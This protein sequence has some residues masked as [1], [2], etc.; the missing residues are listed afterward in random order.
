MANLKVFESTFV[1]KLRE[2]KSLDFY[3]DPNSEFDLSSYPGVVLESQDIKLPDEPPILSPGIKHDAENAEKV[4]NYLKISPLRA[5]DARLW[6]YL[7]H[8]TFC[9]Y[10]KQ[11]WPIKDG[12]V[13]WDRWFFNGG[14]A[15]ERN[16]IARLWWAAYETV[17]PWEKEDEFFK[18][19]PQLDDRFVYTKVLFSTQD[20]AGW[21]R[22]VRFGR[23]PRILIAI[24]EFIR[25]HDELKDR[26]LAR[27]FFKEINLM[28]SYCKLM[29]LSWQ[30]ISDI[31]E[32]VYT[33]LVPDDTDDE[34]ED[35]QRE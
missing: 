1:E 13:T 26:K 33:N 18:E 9:K 14:K 30:Q 12:K 17:A 2:V 23:S 24:L 34:N 25:T 7:T 20:I 6:T 32:D 8:V 21:L 31:F 28:L 3:T 16:A 5:S 22:N 27:P 19:L 29:N 10:V 35:D 4:Y 11:R 15:I